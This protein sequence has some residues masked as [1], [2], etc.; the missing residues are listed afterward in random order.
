MLKTIPIVLTIIFFLNAMESKDTRK[1][2]GNP[3]WFW[4]YCSKHNMCKEG[5]GD[6][7]AD[8]EC[9]GEL[10]CGDDNCNGFLHQNADCCFEP[11]H[12]PICM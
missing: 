6:C 7:D 3:N 12:V 8:L 5:E 10:K 4:N 9:E 2:H 11:A 1:T